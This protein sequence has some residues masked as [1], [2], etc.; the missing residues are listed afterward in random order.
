MNIKGR[1][2]AIFAVYKPG[3][4]EQYQTKDIFHED[5]QA[6]LD[7]VGN[8]REKVLMGDFNARCGTRNGDRVVGPYGES[9][10]N[11]DKE[12]L[13]DLCSQ[14]QP[15]I[16]NSY[17]EHRN[18]HKYTWTQEGRQL[19]TIIDYIITGQTTSFKTS[20][21]RMHRGVECGSGH[22]LLKCNI[23]LS[24]IRHTQTIL[25]ENEFN[26]METLKEDK[27]NIDKL[28]EDSITSERMLR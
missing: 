10:I 15:K 20:D 6:A 4:D 2:L 11:N 19:K 5:L 26:E 14:N 21:V 24:Y 16:T 28:Q 9:T 3:D 12:R 1:R 18:I 27:Y 17:Y 7:E 8:G 23:Y 22:H 13:I 25:Q